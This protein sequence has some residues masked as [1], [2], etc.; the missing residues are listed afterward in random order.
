M[1]IWIVVLIALVTI[2]TSQN[3][4]KSKIGKSFAHDKFTIVP[5]SFFV[6]KELPGL[7]DFDGYG[8]NGDSVVTLFEPPKNA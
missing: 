5:N 3:T 8:M 6:I 4:K 7:M 1:K 2:A